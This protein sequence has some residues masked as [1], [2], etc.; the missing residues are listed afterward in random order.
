VVVDDAN[1]NPCLEGF[2]DTCAIGGTAVDRKNQL[3][4]VFKG[5]GDRPLGDAMTIAVALRDVPLG[6]RA[7]CAERSNHDRSTSKSVRIK[8]ADHE[9][10]LPLFASGTQ[11][12]NQPSCV[13]EEV[14]IVQG[15]VVAIKELA[16][17]DWVGKSTTMEERREREVQILGDQ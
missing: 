13:G 4:A 5:G 15:A 11:A 6:N 2:G 8:I 10:R 12:R 16:R 17:M 14:R 9:D 3:N 7:N 1:K